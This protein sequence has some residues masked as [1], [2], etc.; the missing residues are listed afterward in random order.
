MTLECKF[1]WFPK[2][3]NYVISFLGLITVGTYFKF[4]LNGQTSSVQTFQYKIFIYRKGNNVYQHCDEVIVYCLIVLYFP[5]NKH[6]MIGMQKLSQPVAQ[7][8]D[9]THTH[10]HTHT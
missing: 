8:L 6:K 1:H 2:F 4:C 9:L 10:T 5:V 3:Y 7:W